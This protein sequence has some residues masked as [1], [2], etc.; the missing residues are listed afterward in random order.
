MGKRGFRELEVWQRAKELAVLVYRISAESPLSADFGLRNQIRRSAVS[1][2][3]NIGEG[4][5]RGS[6]RDAVRFF[7]IAKGS[8]AEL[9][10]QITIAAESG[11]MEESAYQAPDMHYETVGNMIGAL[12]QARSRSFRPLPRTS[13]P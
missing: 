12:I 10:T 9:R 3:S 8:V 5:E 1:V 4:D 7:F 6:D 2:A 11:L 13:R